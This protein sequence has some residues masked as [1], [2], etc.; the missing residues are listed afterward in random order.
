MRVIE[1]NR[2]IPC[3]DGRLRVAQNDRLMIKNTS[4]VPW[5]PFKNRKSALPGKI[6]G[7]TIKWGKACGRLRKKHVPLS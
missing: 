2:T 3:V 5:R 7:V 1:I 4:E 6:Y